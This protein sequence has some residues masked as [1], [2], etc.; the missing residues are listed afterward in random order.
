[1]SSQ[2]PHGSSRGLV[3]ELHRNSAYLERRAAL[4]SL[5]VTSGASDGLSRGHPVVPD[6]QRSHS[7]IPGTHQIGVQGV[8]A[9]L[10]DEEQTLPGPVLTAG[11][12]AARA[13]L[14]GI[15]GIHLDAHRPGEHR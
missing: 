11:V 12:A 3:A 5:S 1:M 13:G 15:V 10:T 6:D 4:A 7:D 8:P 9:L 2:I 14:A